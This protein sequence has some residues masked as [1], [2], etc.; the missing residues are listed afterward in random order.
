MVLFSSTIMFQ[1]TVMDSFLGLFGGDDWVDNEDH[2]KCLS[3]LP[4]EP[5]LGN[6]EYKL[7][8]VN[9]SKQRF[10]HLV[11]QVIAKYYLKFCTLI[12]Q[13]LDFIPLVA[14]KMEIK[15]RPRRSN[16]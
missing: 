1:I 10:E 16:I 2:T 4:P 6:V 7:K 5:Q 11:T 13:A 12:C 8:L 15:R 3:Q 9:P 14:V